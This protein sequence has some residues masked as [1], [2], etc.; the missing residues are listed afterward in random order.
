VSALKLTA[1]K[2]ERYKPAKSDEILTDGNGL[3]L[4][5]RRAQDGSVTRTWLYAY[6]AGTKSI[7]LT[8]GEHNT[9]LSDF[10][11]VLYR[12]PAEACLTLEMA[13][14]IA[15]EIKDWRTR[16]VDPKKRMADERDKVAA[17]A[18][19][20]ASLEVLAQTN[21]QRD[22]LT[23][24]DLFDE[25]IVDG[26]RRKDGNAALKRLFGVDVLPQIGA[27]SIRL[28]TEHDIRSVLRAQ[29]SR[30]VNR[31]AVI[32]RNSLTQMF[33]WG[34]KRQPWRRLLVDGDPMEL[35][36]IE[37]IVSPDYDLS[38]Q[39]DR[40]LSRGE[41]AE[42]LTALRRAEDEYRA[43]PNKRLA[44]QPLEK[45]TQYAIWIM[46]ST[47]CRVG[48]MT[49]ARWEHVD[50]SNAE[51][52]IPKE[53]VKGN[54]AHLLVYLSPFALEQFNALHAIT[55]TTE[56][57]FPSRSGEGH[58]DIKSIAK[59]IGDR[60]RM[61]KKAKS[62]ISHPSKTHRRQDNTLVLANAR[63]G[64]WSPH[65]LRRTG[66]TMM[67]A[68]GTSL[69]TI[70]RCQN[71]IVFGSKVRRVYLRHDYAN[72]KRDAWVRLGGDLQSILRKT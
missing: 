51:W 23:V 63:N 36:E 43:A 54:L 59:Q 17:D 45:K 20:K 21:L 41:I 11:I 58:M 32:T 69:D 71:H 3:S 70:D 6:K 68:L 35:I 57:C 14:R 9:A 67:Q 24:K 27:I 28:L 55:G 53:N 30:G 1:T 62:Q 48:E 18:A 31:T 65:D 19:A 26:V 64:S 37:K 66:A 33:A 46:L 7:Y 15:V 40:I 4:R 38:N 5:L 47:M 60:Q 25:W 22:N 52:F 61:F 49:M 13:R 42:L 56:W 16:G 72:E 50:L 39:S 12:L 10:D 34:R 8:L 2:V 29:V 44:P